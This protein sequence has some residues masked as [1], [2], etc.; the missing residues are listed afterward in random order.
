MIRFSKSK[1]NTFLTCPE[2]YRLYYELGIRATKASPSLVEGSCIHHLL[3]SGVMYGRHV[4][5]ILEQASEGFWRDHPL[6]LC[7][8]PS[9]ADYLK[10][11]VT[12]LSQARVFLEQLGPIEARHIELRVDSPL[13]HPVTLAEHPGISLTGFIDMVLEGAD[14]SQYVVDLKT[15]Q[16]S[17][18]EG[19]ARVA[20][21][22]SLYAYLVSLPIAPDFL[23]NVPVA[24]I[25]LIR[26]KSPQVQFDES[27]RTLSHFVELYRICRKVAQD[28]EAGLFWKNPGMHCGWCD[29]SPF[30]YGEEEV[31][32][33]L[34]GREVWERYMEDQL[35][36]S[37]VELPSAANF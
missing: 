25:Y 9:E 18:R 21:E 23:P 28:I 20:L 1:L 11:R 30:C 26:T 14:G 37:R 32:V 34:Y 19:M 22:L 3:E 29:S 8:Y 31:A 27:R 17:P 10:A 4:E 15:V 5:D 33:R 13:I 24:L 12:C 36:R 16:R 35:E 6:E 7:N 2:K